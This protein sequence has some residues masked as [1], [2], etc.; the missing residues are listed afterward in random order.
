MGRNLGKNKF[1]VSSAISVI[2]IMSFL[3][4]CQPTSYDYNVDT[5]SSVSMLANDVY[6]IKSIKD[7]IARDRVLDDVIIKV[8]SKNGH[9]RIAGAVET[10]TQAEKI[11]KLAQS[12]PGVKSL[13]V[14]DLKAKN[15]K[16][17]LT[18]NY[19]TA[20]IKGLFIR[21]GILTTPPNYIQVTTKN[22]YVLVKGEVEDC[23]MVSQVSSLLRE[24]NEIRSF[25]N[26][27]KC[28]IAVPKRVE[29]H[30]SVKIIE[31]AEL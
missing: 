23:D 22:Q 28:T 18:D 3:S 17:S 7:K 14:V 21:E 25:K 5:E 13:G 20:K 12:V 1:L 15:S 4:G 31:D 29:V 26:N 11:V 30:E 10:R 6:I 2:A 19:I 27:L 24:I 8:Y 16:I 9:V